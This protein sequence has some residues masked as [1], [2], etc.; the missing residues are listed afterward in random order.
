MWKVTLERMTYMRWLAAALL[1]LLAACAGQLDLL[2]RP[3]R[4]WPA[5]KR[6]DA[7]A[8]CVIR[9]LNERGRSESNLVQSRTY[10]KHVIEP[11][12]IYEI[13]ADADRTVAAE[14]AVVRLEKIDDEITRLS[15]FVKSPWKK[16]VI[17]VLKPCGTRS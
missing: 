3:D 13:R 11:G 10:A 17:R 4:V 8:S 15:L 6:I 12:N 5:P 14:A 16:E 2:D 1:V 7:V 9:V